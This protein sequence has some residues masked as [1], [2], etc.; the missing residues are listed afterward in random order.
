MSSH[1][2]SPTLVLLHGLFSSPME[3]ALLSRGLRAR[4]IALDSLE[5]P[6][7]TRAAPRHGATRHDWIEAAR[8]ALDRR[9]A[10]G[11]PIVLGGLCAGAAIAAGLATRGVRQHVRGLVLMSP[12]VAYDGWSLGPLA[13]L[14][15]IACRLGLGRWLSVAEADPYGIKNPRTRQWVRERIVDRSSSFGPARIPL[16]GIRETERLFGEVFDDL[17]S[18]GVPLLVMHAREDEITRLAS[19]ERALAR[20]G[21]AHKLL[22]LEDSYH[23]ITIDND[24]ARVATALADFVDAARASGVAD[25]SPVRPRDGREPAV[26]PRRA[27]P[28]WVAAGSAP[29]I[30]PAK[31]LHGYV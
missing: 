7:Y 11:T 8:R 22:V 9:Y 2:S 5:V 27:L 18:A 15:G 31:E 29:R 10:A 28:R 1:Q 21:A 16:S 6:G 25:R 17:S 20:S 26:R 24:R 30:E 23:M 12:A 13:C 14:R 3:F 19:V 4:G